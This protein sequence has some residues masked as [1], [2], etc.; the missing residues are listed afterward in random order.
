MKA[1]DPTIRIGAVATTTRRSPNFVFP[2]EAVTD[3]VTRR[4]PAGWVPVMLST[5]KAAGVM[6][7]FLICHRYEQ[8]PWQ[9]NDAALLQMAGSPTTG[10]SVN[11]ALLRG[12]L[13]DYFGAA[14]A[15]VELCVTES[16]SVHYNPGK[17]TTTFVNGLYLADSVGF[18]LQTEFNCLLWFGARCAQLTGNDNDTSLYGWR[19]YGDYGVICTHTDLS[20]DLY[21]TYYVMKLLSRFARGGDT[22]VQAASDNTLLPV[23]AVNVRTGRWAC[24]WS[25]RARSPQSPETLR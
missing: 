1:V 20:T 4:Q 11:A 13:N 9:E 10:W 6:P 3:P 18:L 2:A 24:W 15:R 21:P 5:M 7:D 8:N 22:V 16:N 12:P 25:T 17:Q 19:L 14:A 23:Y